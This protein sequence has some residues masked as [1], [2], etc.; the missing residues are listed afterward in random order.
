MTVAS[1]A[2]S[3]LAELV[4][5]LVSGLPLYGLSDRDAFRIGVRA[6]TPCPRAD[7]DNTLWIEFWEGLRT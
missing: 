2:R 3:G 1:L 7:T 4:Y 5:R 6:L